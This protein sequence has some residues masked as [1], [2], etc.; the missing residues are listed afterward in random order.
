MDMDMDTDTD[1]DTYKATDTYKDTDTYKAT[2]TLAMWDMGMGMGT[3]Q[4]IN[5]STKN[6]QGLRLVD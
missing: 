4:R 1:T 5:T 6:T 2:D 3:R